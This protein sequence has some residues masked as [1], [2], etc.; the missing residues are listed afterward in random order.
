MFEIFIVRKL[1]YAVIYT[2]YGKKKDTQNGLQVN[3]LF[4]ILYF[5]FATPHLS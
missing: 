2:Q 3:K 1:K 4:H 5:F